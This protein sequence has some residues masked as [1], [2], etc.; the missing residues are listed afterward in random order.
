MIKNVIFDVDGVIRTIKIQPVTNFLSN[1]LAEKYG[2]RYDG[3]TIRNYFDK[4]LHNEIFDK[5]DLGQIDLQELIKLIS[6]RHNEPIEVLQEVMSRR[7][8]L[9][10]NI[11]FVPTMN[12]IKKLKEEGY[13]IFILS[14]MGIDMAQVL[15][16]VFAECE[17]DDIVFSSEVH[18]MKPNLEIYEYALNRFNARPEE[19]LFVDDRLVNLEPFKKLGG[20]IYEFNPKNVEESVKGLEEMLTPSTFSK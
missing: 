18:M 14:N 6:E 19:C 4:L 9:Q 20:N 17:F 12:L 15:K 3:V 5:F 1:E 10:N 7:L 11:F 16:E 8:E 13:N 2:P